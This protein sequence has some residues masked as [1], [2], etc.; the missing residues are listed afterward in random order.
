MS[1]RLEI[2]ISGFYLRPK[3]VGDHIALGT[4]GEAARKT[5]GGR[6]GENVCITGVGLHFPLQTQELVPVIDQGATTAEQGV[7]RRIWVGGS[8]TH[9]GIVSYCFELGPHDFLGR[10]WY[11]QR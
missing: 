1:E 7:P 11:G 2:V 6:D 10:R 4:A 3:Q 5:P 8:K 9:V